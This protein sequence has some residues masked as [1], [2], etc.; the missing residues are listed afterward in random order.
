[1]YIALNLVQMEA[2]SAF[3]R[4]VFVITSVVISVTC[5]AVKNRTFSHCGSWEWIRNELIRTPPFC[6]FILCLILA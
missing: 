5:A 3:D 1:M 2:F 6:P 4:N